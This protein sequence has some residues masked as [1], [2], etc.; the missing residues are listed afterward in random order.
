MRSVREFRVLAVP[1]LATASALAVSA[2]QAPPPQSLTDADRTAIQETTNAALDIANGSKDWN[3]YV[4]TYYAPDAIVMPPNHEEL[5]G[6]SEIGI[7]FDTFPSF[8]DLRFNIQHLEGAGDMAYAQGTYSMMLTLPGSNRAEHDQGKY[9]EVW[10][11]QMDG[12]WQVA[13]DIFN[14]DRPTSDASISGEGSG[15]G[16]RP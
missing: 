13:F 6:R 12:T 14:S 11:K 3:A 1:A 15:G 16:G 8:T 2:C 10:R 7:W 4:D 9:L 5:Q